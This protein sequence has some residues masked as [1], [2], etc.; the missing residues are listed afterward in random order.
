MTQGKNIRMRTLFIA[1]LCVLA[2]CKPMPPQQDPSH[3]AIS[4]SPYSQPYHA[5]K[6]P[7]TTAPA[8]AAPKTT[9]HARYRHVKV[10]FLAP[11]S[12]TSA[13][14]GKAMLDAAMLGLFDVYAN[15]PATDGAIR[16]QLMPY[17]TPADPKLAAKATEQAIADGA[18]VILGP[19]YSSSV[20]AAAPIAGRRGIPMINFS[21]NASVAGSGNYMFGFMPLEQVTKVLDAAMARGDKRIAALLPA[22]PY[23]DVVEEA[24][25]EHTEAHPTE[26]A[27]VAHY[28]LDGSDIAPYV[29]RLV[30][31][32][33]LKDTVP[34][35]ALLLAEGGEPFI[36]LV[37]QLKKFRLT[38]NEVHYLGTGLLDDR[39]LLGLPDAAG[40]WFATTPTRAYEGFSTRFEAEYGYRPPRLA[41]LGYDGVALVAR[42]LEQGG[43]TD[44][45]MTRYHGFDLPANGL[46][47]F[48]KDGSNERSLAVMALGAQTMEEVVPAQRV[49]P[50]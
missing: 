14:M 21:N 40:T 18:Q 37:K 10:A 34:F 8:P 3:A 42:L 45:T 48:H 28:P 25:I 32:V 36:Q 41:S 39:S 33:A 50:E 2:A 17:D 11:L 7:S 31:N 24:L 13:E 15:A 43:V 1:L 47:R 20:A 16:V 38:P 46:I 22:S 44:G 5:A 35:D 6:Q 23:G 9:P 29:Q 19:L 30:G 49:L 12:D 27:G 4:P 26:L